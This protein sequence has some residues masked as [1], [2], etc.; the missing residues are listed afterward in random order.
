MSEE[1]IQRRPSEIAVET[2]RTVHSVP[3]GPG[4]Q[5]PGASSVQP[6]SVTTPMLA[7]GHVVTFG[8]VYQLLHTFEMQQIQRVSGLRYVLPQAS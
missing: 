6:P 2:A 1:T 8:D 4:I 5:D 3:E 7:D